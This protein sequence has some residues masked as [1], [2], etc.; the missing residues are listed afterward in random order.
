MRTSTTRIRTR[1]R[2]GFTL[3]EVLTVIAIIGIL[4]GLTVPAV[5]FAYRTVKKRAIALEV[6]TISDAIEKY[7]EKYG[8]YPPDGSSGTVI[9]RHLRKVFP[10]IA[11]R[12]ID[13][14]VAGSNASTGLSGAVMDPAESLVFFLGGFSDDPIF[15]FTG[16]GGPFAATPAGSLTP[17]Q[18]NVDRVNPLYEFKQALLTLEVI[19]DP[20]SGVPIT[21][22][23]DETDYGFPRPSSFPGDIIPVYRGSGKQ[24]PYVYF[25]SRTYSVGG[26][27]NRYQSTAF[28]VVRPYKSTDLNTSNPL[29]RVGEGFYRYAAPKTF[30]II[31]AGLDDDFGG[32]P[33]RDPTNLA[34]V[35]VFFRYPSGESLDITALPNAQT[36]TR[37]YISVVGEPSMQLDNAAN[38]SEGVLEDSL[39][40]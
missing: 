30:Q 25:D 29:V 17:I 20:N 3:V 38:F 39:E 26:Q 12:E 24:A 8:D 4:V 1:H 34:E 5:L 18:Y 7:K 28:G 9:I 21:V 6:I 23:R 13:L 32:V 14:L 19:N 36:P 10:Q 2:P 15:P 37:G 27:F 16:T 31:S 40:N 35:P 11:Q 33:T 22:S